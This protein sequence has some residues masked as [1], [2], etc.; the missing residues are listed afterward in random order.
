MTFKSSMDFTNRIHDSVAMPKIYIPNKM[1]NVIS[2][3]G[4]KADLHD[5]IDYTIIDGKDT[6]SVQER[7]RRSKYKHYRD[8]TFRYDTPEKPGHKREFFKI[9]ADLFLYGIVNDAEDDFEWAIMF[10]VKPVVDAV[11]DGTIE[12]TYKMN[13]GPNDSGF[14]AIDI[15]DLDRI[16]ATILK[17][18]L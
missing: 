13:V 10:S 3:V 14:I 12:S 2:E 17:Y 18:K 16:D 15:E 9:K 8:I 4:T 1:S 6:Y 5:G 11:N 7:F